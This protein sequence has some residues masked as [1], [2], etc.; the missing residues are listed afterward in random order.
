MVIVG[1]GECGTRAAFALRDAGYDGPIDL[2]GSERHLPYERPPLSKQIMLGAAGLPPT[3]IAT[4]ERLLDSAI[5]YRPGRTVLSLDRDRRQVCL[6][7]GT[8]LSYRRLLLATGAKPRKL[9]LVGASG[10]Q[11]VTLRSYDDAVAIRG[12]FGPNQRVA[13]IGGGFIGLELA[14]AARAHQVDVT[15]IEAQPRLLARN[16]PEELALVLADRH[17]AAGVRILVAA[18]LV[19]IETGGTAARLQLADGTAIEA[20]LV[21][22][23]IGAIPETSLA[24]SSGLAVG[25]GI[26]VNDRL[27]TSDPDILAAGDCCAFPHPLFEGRVLRLESWRSAQEQG[28]LAARNMVGA[29]EAVSA[30]PWFW[31]DQYDLGMQIAGLPDEGQTLVRRQREGTVVL[32][33]LKADGRIVGAAGVGVGNAVARD[34]RVAEMLI[35]RRATPSPEALVRPDVKLKSLLA[36]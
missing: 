29:E 8:V 36:A 3:T 26:I 7:D 19:G 10:A 28:T 16:V 25:N 2:V 11:F 5:R 31:T 33:H 6:D 12:R 30:V 23:G 13:I 18:S 20:D 14:A 22:V 21:I 4:A 32:F 35:A 17:R 34:I 27:F 24:A 1:A 15:I 9:N